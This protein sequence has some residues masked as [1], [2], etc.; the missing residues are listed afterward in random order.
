MEFKEVGHV[1]VCVYLHTRLH[2]SQAGNHQSWSVQRFNKFLQ[3][4]INKVVLY[5]MSE[6]GET[7]FCAQA[8]LKSKWGI[9]AKALLFVNCVGQ[10]SILV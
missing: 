10:Q 8:N 1:C 7:I 5:R 6:K 9:L 4:G 3:Q 2:V